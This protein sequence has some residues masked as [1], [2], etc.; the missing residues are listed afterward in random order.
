MFRL[1]YVLKQE[2]ESELVLRFRT[3][4]RLFMF[5]F[6]ALVAGSIV[7]SGPNPSG[8]T[9]LPPLFL[10]FFILA[11]LYDERWIMDREKR[12]LLHRNGLIPFA[13]IRSYPFDSIE[14]LELDTFQTHKKIIRLSFLLADG[15]RK[16]VEISGRKNRE[17]IEERARRMAA[18]MSLSFRTE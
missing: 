6:A 4:F 2:S 7:V 8:L 14:A 9:F 15:S 12:L 1:D 17:E 16:D 13:S 11:G 5:I 3:S 10:L 18:F